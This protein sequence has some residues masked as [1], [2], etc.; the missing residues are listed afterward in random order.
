MNFGIEDK[1]LL[2]SSSLFRRHPRIWWHFIVIMNA[3]CLCI[4]VLLLSSYLYVFLW[5][6]EK[7]KI[8]IYR[9]FKIL[10]KK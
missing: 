1:R 7:Q 2:T 4:V 6:L 5:I 3:D 8:A 10:I 9:F